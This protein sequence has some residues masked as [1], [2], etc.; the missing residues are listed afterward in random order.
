MRT[1]KA[2]QRVDPRQSQDQS[3]RSVLVVV[4][5]REN[6]SRLRRVS[7]LS[8]LRARA[9]R[10]Q[11]ARGGAFE[12]A[13]PLAERSPDLLARVKAW[14]D[15]YTDQAIIIV[16]VLLGLWLIGKGSYLLAT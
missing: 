6:L 3:P 2:T 11:R 10:V 12:L 9:H 1:R 16:S 14:I 4:A 5:E 13:D 7:L 8:L 15:T